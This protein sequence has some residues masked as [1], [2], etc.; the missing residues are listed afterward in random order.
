MGESD[1]VY[2]HATGLSTG[3]RSHSLPTHPPPERFKS[4]VQVTRRKGCPRSQGKL[5]MLEITPLN[6]KSLSLTEMTGDG[7]F[8]LYRIPLVR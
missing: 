6:C 3:Q 4:C 7:S 1:D 8:I 5:L 2:A